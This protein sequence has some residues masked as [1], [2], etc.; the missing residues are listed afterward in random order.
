MTHT[1]GAAQSAY[2][3]TGEMADVTG[4][5]YLRARYYSPLAGRFMSRDTWEGNA[6]QP[7]TYNE[8]NYGQSN[9]V[10]HIDPSGYCSFIPWDNV[11]LIDEAINLE[12]SDWVNTY[13]ATGVAVQCWAD[14]FQDKL[15]TDDSSGLGPAQV[16]NQ[17][18][19]NPYGIIINGNGA[20]LR[21]YISIMVR[22]NPPCSFCF[23]K[24]EKDAIPNFDN[25][26]TL[27]PVH[28]QK[29]MDWAAR[30]MRRRIQSVLEE[31]NKC[32]STDK[33][34]AAALAQNAGFTPE[35]MDKNVAPPSQGYRYLNADGKITESPDGTTIRWRDYLTSRNNITDTFTQIFRFHPTA[36]TFAG[37]GWAIPNDLHHETISSLSN[38]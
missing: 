34:I 37:L 6:Y 27:E 13:A 17:Q 4:L 23:T 1:N 26:Y 11:G 24:D 31:C 16:S 20:G 2:G 19:S 21:C 10:N 12:K 36:V 25:L 14:T 18:I 32:S 35:D 38:P 9:P 28:D 22:H 33:F 8:W 15:P 29:D 7:I 30:Y 5:T 3:F